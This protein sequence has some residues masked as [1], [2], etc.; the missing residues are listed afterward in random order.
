MLKIYTV[1]Y[2]VYD[3]KDPSDNKLMSLYFIKYN[4]TRLSFLFLSI[5]VASGRA[6][7]K[8]DLKRPFHINRA[9]N[10]FPQM[11]HLRSRIPLSLFAWN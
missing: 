7:M 2:T 6:F 11:H 1:E 8:S 4:P 5:L 10:A 3:T 9:S